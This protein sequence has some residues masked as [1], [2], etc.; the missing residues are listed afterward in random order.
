MS[1]DIESIH[2]FNVGRYD[3]GIYM[4][5]YIQISQHSDVCQGQIDFYTGRPQKVAP[6]II[7][8]NN[9]AFMF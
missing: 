8:I 7:I 9:N 4:Y 3:V 2:M 5:T 6:L 1:E